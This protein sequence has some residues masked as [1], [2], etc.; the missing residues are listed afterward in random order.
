MTG[1]LADV[2]PISVLEPDGLI[3]TT[4]GRYVR[5]IECERVPNA[6]T[7]DPVTLSAIERAYANVCRTIPDHQGIVV[8]A[9]TDPV[10]LREALEGDLEL[11]RAAANADRAA[12]HHALAD[13][14]GRLLEATTQT[15]LAAAGA[16]QPAVA[17]RWWVAVPYLP[18]LET[19]R[20]QLRSLA[21]R[22]RGR[23][24]W[25]AH[26]DAAIESARITSQIEA[27]LRAAGIET[28]LLGWYPDAR[29]GVGAAPP[30]DRCR[31]R[32]GPARRSLPGGD[33]DDDRSGTRCAPSRRARGL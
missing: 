25:S 20:E 30:R 27:A 24:P 12:G 8:Y 23:V 33:R 7:A 1:S 22:S 11:T 2:V 10:P 6:V 14:R 29:A 15:V 31:V 28:Y 19:P 26:R 32:P 13:A 5:L 3:V 21:A 18:R 17:A 9:Q 16:E 4:S